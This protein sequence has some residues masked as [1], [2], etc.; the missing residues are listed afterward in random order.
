MPQNLSYKRLL[1]VCA[2]AFFVVPLFQCDPRPTTETI[3]EI[4]KESTQDTL[5][6]DASP[7]S[8]EISDAQ[9]STLEPQ[10]E[11]EPRLEPLPE[12]QPEPKP[13]PQPEPIPETPA[14][15]EGYRHFSLPN[16]YDIGKKLDV[17][18]C[19][20]EPDASSCT[21][22]HQGS[23]TAM[24]LV[25]VACGFDPQKERDR[26]NYL[27]QRVTEG[28]LRTEPFKRLQQTFSI[29]RNDD[30]QTGFDLTHKN[31]YCYEAWVQATGEGAQAKPKWDAKNGIWYSSTLLDA[32]KRC[33]AHIVVVIANNSGWSGG[34]ANKWSGW[35]SIVGS[36]NDD[37]S[38]RRWRTGTEAACTAWTQRFPGQC[39]WDAPGQ[40]C[41]CDD[42]L[43]D[44]EAGLPPNTRRYPDCSQSNSLGCP[45]P[46]T[47][48]DVFMEYTAIHEVGHTIGDFAHPS[49]GTTATPVTAGT[50]PPNCYL[51]PQ[52]TTPDPNTPCP[53]WNKTDFTQWVLP[54]DAQGNEPKRFGC[55]AGCADNKALYAPWQGAQMMIRDDELH[56]GFSP[57]E[58]E[59][60]SRRLNQNQCFVIGQTNYQN[61]QQT[62]QPGPT[63]DA[64]Y[65]TGLIYK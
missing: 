34:S 61:T 43:P 64:L 30:L 48:P 23:P 63:F 27:V 31:S 17:K 41:L 47:H 65:G 24:R 6:Q 54:E 52:G 53:P 33:Q 32:G 62:C 36:G 19:V 2:W 37:R 35:M 44:Q 45:W 7:E 51:P 57:V 12:P 56:Y 21:P 60:L 42:I 9:E 11:S 5:K 18:R 50:E 8:T 59:I 49:P 10:P 26:Y 14:C 46:F 25:T 20:K 22:I 13:E 4:A 39:A 15:P 28:F 16:S 40:R 38:I 55:F 3:A 1:A 29:V 58:R